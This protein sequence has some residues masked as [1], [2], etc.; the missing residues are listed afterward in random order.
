[1]TVESGKTGQHLRDQ[2]V[3]QGKEERMRAMQALSGAYLNDSR[4]ALSS[5]LLAALGGRPM[6]DDVSQ[7]DSA[8]VEL[9]AGGEPAPIAPLMVGE[10]M[11]SMQTCAND[12]HHDTTELISAS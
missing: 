7:G 12:E 9:S 11:A 5:L 10:V 4:A 1:M 3:E 2:V 6:S 8:F